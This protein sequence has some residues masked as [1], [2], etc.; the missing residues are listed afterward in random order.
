MN[1]TVI[2]DRVV[3]ID[4]NLERATYAIVDVRGNILARDYIITA[5]Y[6]NVNDFV[7][8]LCDRLFDLAMA[9]GG[10]DTIRSVAV[11][12][13]S[14]NFITGCI[15]NSPNMPWKGNIPLAAMMRDRLGLAVAV[16][17]N[18]HAKALGEYAFGCAHGMKDFIVISLG[19]GLGSCIFSNE[20]EHQGTNGFGG[21]VGHTCYEYGGRQCGCG[22]KGC[23][24]AYTASKGIVMTALEV[25]AER[26]EPSMMRTE[27]KLTAQAIIS[28]CDQGDRL[29]AEVMRR[30]GYAL[31]VGLANYASIFDPEAI[32]FTGY[33]SQAGESL[34]GPAREAFDAHVFRNIAGKVEFLLSELSDCERNVLGASVLA[35][36]V[37]EYSLF[38]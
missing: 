2:K 35:W 31:G 23:L 29:A 28:F 22:K 18:A 12:V 32:I 27:E 30:T 17:N 5:E 21:E 14:G 11:S 13:P 26:S 7:S 20:A 37:K 6:P 3:G 10:C 34:L 4:I 19:S 25:L 24:E 38:R 15:E 33:V 1:E 36:K 16:A 8:I 9:N